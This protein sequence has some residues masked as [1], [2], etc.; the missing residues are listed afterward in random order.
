MEDIKIGSVVFWNKTGAKAYW[1]TDL[2]DPVE[3][4][5]EEFLEGVDDGGHGYTEEFAY[6]V[7]HEGTS[8]PLSVVDMIA[9][10]VTGAVVQKNGVSFCPIRMPFTFYNLDGANHDDSTK[11]LK[12]FVNIADL[13]IATKKEKKEAENKALVDSITSYDPITNKKITSQ[14]DKTAPQADNADSKSS[15]GT[16]IIVGV[17]ILV[18]GGIIYYFATRNKSNN[19]PQNYV[20][21][22][23]NT[24]QQVRYVMPPNRLQPVQ[25]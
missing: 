20:Q 13:T 23:P 21:A 16:I 7:P 4:L 15:T 18:F 24:V 2:N 25:N 11:S 9:G 14:T 17:V 5:S 6:D 19:V 1:R 10:T 3:F 22:P 12:V 8:I